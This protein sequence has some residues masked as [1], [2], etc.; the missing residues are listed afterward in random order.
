MSSHLSVD[1]SR[2]ELALGSAGAAWFRGLVAV[3]VV[4]L[5]GAL[6]LA[7]ATT[8]GWARF[9]PSYLVSFVFFLSLALGALFFVLL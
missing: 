4:G 8:G 2:D 3:G 5:G 7:S 1:L 9:Y 6:A